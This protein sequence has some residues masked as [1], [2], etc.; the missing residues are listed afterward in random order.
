MQ[1]V[2]CSLYDAMT[3]DPSTPRREF[4]IFQSDVELILPQDITMSGVMALLTMRYSFSQI[5][6][7]WISLRYVERHR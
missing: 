1:S 4:S 6:E 5:L 7:T 3:I 2:P